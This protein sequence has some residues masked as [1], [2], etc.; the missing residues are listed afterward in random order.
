M[1]ADEA[2][3]E[4][5]RRELHKNVMSNIEQIL[6]SLSISYHIYQPLRLGKIWLKVNF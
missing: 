3:R 4:K 5:T 1:D 2:Y 6:P